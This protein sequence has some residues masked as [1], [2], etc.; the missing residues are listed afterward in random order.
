MILNGDGPSLPTRRSFDLEGNAGVTPFT[1]TVTLSP[2]STGTVTVNYATANGTALAGSDYTAV[3]PTV[4][5]FS[6]AQTSKLVT[7]NV[8]GNTV[9]EPNETFFVSLSN[10]V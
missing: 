10:A 9:V 3:P 7:V 8:L 2:A 5:T 1:F 6:P 4:L